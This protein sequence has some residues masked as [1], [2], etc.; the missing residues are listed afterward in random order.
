MLPLT[1]PV[2]K[3]KITFRKADLNF[4]HSCDQH[5]TARPPG[6]Y[7]RASVGV[8][9]FYLFSSRQINKSKRNIDSPTVKTVSSPWRGVIH[10]N[11]ICWPNGRGKTERQGW[12]RERV[13]RQVSSSMSRV[14]E[15][16]ERLAMTSA[17]LSILSQR[18]CRQFMAGTR[19]AWGLPPL[20]FTWP[21]PG[22]I[23]TFAE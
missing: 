2:T 4:F 13:V 22:N 14:L 11:W 20:K 15:L 8:G 10:S 16:N 21:L 1:S 19:V 12:K 6:I 7:R 23:N 3:N 5:A 18:R 17:S 9:R